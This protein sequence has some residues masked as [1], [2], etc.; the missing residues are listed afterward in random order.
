VSY[1]VIARKWRPQKFQELV[2]QN[3]ISQTLSNA[4]THGRLPHALLF[5]GPRGTGK[6]SSARILAKSLRCPNSIDFVPCGVCDS[7]QEIATG[8]AT[9]VIEIDG[10]SNNGV[11][12]IRDLREGVIFAPSSGK[13]KIYIIDEVHMLSTSAFNALLK[14]LEEPPDHVIF[15]MA[16]TEVQKIPQ[17]ILSRCQR[18][19]FRR[20]STRVIV[21]HMSFICK[22][23]KIQ[24]ED[25]ALWTIARQGD[26]S[27][28]DALSLL[29]QVI[30]F[31]NGPLKTEQVVEILGLT[32][33]SLLTGVLSSM[34]SRQPQETLK[35]LEK[36]SS[37]GT[38]PGLFMN[39]L[40]ELIRTTLLIKI[41]HDQSDDS[42]P[43]ML[44]LPD[45]ELRFLKDLGQTCSE[46]DLHLLF[47]M[48][49][50]GA[51][52]LHRSSEP[53]I[54]LEM[55]LLRMSTAPQIVD[56]K[57]LLSG[58]V[59]P[60]KPAPAK[61]T[62]V[63]PVS[64]A[65][66]ASAITPKAPSRSISLTPSEKWFEFVQTIKGN[67]PLLG[68]KI[69]NLLFLGETGKVIE[70]A[71]PHKMNFLKD[72]ISD[73]TLRKKLQNLIE[74]AWGPGYALEIKLENKLADGAVSASGI[75]QVKE[76][77]KEDDLYKQ[78]I[79]HP[80][81][82]SAASAFKGSVKFKNKETP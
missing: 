44:D 58:N 75:A 49:L 59:L 16:T 46:E 35:L 62:T 38:E 66:Q 76:K 54:V 81:V 8:R 63:A 19:D 82:K 67:D 14:T 21:D 50:K 15:I 55:V 28:R 20:I 10:A 74:T 4:L 51:G 61:V 1:Q 2:G 3:H 23:D 65:P 6:T 33:R 34:I 57:K 80:K 36:L 31:S 41:S 69:E 48:A 26:G 73:P 12:A 52:D 18:F 45:S 11:D 7:C 37:S 25:E 71:I 79:D 42:K 70:L 56:L 40:L 30:T 39:D 24:A 9:D 77:K 13:Y 68:A 60:A 64:P 47:D 43:T 32:E 17:T 22:Q 53:R 29:D 27:M 78:V 72:Q 5:T